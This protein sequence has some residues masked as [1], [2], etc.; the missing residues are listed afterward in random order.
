MNFQRPKKRKKK[1]MTDDPRK[2][3]EWPTHRAF[4]RKHECIVPGCRREDIE[5]CHV[6]DGLPPEDKG[7]TNLKPPDWWCYA[8]CAG[9]H[10]QQHKIGEAPFAGLHGVDLKA[11]AQWLADNTTDKRMRE[12]LKERRTT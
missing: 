4:V 6:R 7:G 11:A 1:R 3:R 8:A 5:A 12:Y 10:R 2:G 9:H